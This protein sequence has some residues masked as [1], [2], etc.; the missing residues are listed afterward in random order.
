[1]SRDPDRPEARRAVGL[2]YERGED[3]APRVVAKGSGEVADRIL[4][5]ARESGV[6]I[7]RDPD[8]VQMLT[9]SELG[10]EIP[11]ELYEGVA[12]LLGWLWRRNAEL[13]EGSGE[14]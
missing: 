7:E 2:Q 14:V 10:E 5:V 11:I 12:R 13:R 1:M 3:A 8:L 9:C 4:A 6:P